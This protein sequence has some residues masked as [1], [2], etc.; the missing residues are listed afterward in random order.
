MVLGRM[1][2]VSE[3]ATSDLSKLVGKQVKA[4]RSWYRIPEG[5]V[6]KVV[7]FHAVDPENVGFWVEWKTSD[8]HTTRNGFNRMMNKSKVCMDE[9]QWLEVVEEN[10]E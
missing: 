2:K 3:I 4:L 10:S 5:S 9:T 8:G 1:R 7:E 6:G